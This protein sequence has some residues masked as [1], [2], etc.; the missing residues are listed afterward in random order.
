MIN[1]NSQMNP[2]N[3][4]DN[5]EIYEQLIQETPIEV[6]NFLWSPAYQAIIDSI[7]EAYRLSD[8]QSNVVKDAIF[9]IAIG[10]LD[11]AGAKNKLNDAKIDQTTQNKIFLVAFEYV[12]NPA[13]QKSEEIIEEI[14]E[15]GIYDEEFSENETPEEKVGDSANKKL[16]SEHKTY[17]T[18]DAVLMNLNKKLNQSTSVNPV[19]RNHSVENKNSYKKEGG[20]IDPYREIPN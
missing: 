1:Q 8:E 13:I 11:E 4:Q 3:K 6:R 20:F 2:N 18:N 16:D 19:E 7:K 10:Y 12:I 17:K 14:K 9:E 15:F 5:I